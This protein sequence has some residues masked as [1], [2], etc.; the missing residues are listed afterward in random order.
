MTGRRALSSAFTLCLLA[1]IP[2]QA[3]PKSVPVTVQGTVETAP[4]RF[5]VMVGNGS[6]SAMPDLAEITGGV[7]SHARRAGD[8]LHANSEAMA[9]AVTAL[10]ALGISDKEITTIDFSFSP[11]YDTDS[12]GNR[13]PSNR[14]VG[15][16]VSNRIKVSLTDLS[17]A[18]NALDALIAS[19]ANDSTTISFSVRDS[20]ALEMRARAAA[21]K[22][23]LARAQIYAKEVGAELGPVRSIREGM[24]R[25]I[26][27]TVE[28]V[29]VS[30]ARDTRIQADEQSV[31]V[32]VTVVW[33]LK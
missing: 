28:S 17:K 16:D 11:Q 15:Y 7:V 8:A 3:A 29:V 12:K 24:A 9:K 14:I 23:A 1:A 25:D 19:G 22:D 33:A 5:V 21:G 20:H 10:K 32:Q 27:P 26:E 2:A 30:A 4:D 18:G 6:A 31:S 13:D